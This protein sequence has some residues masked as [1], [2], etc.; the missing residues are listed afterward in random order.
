[1]LNRA[2]FFFRFHGIVHAF[3]HQITFFFAF[4]FT[5]CH[6]NAHSLYLSYDSFC[7]L[8]NKRKAE[9]KLHIYTTVFFQTVNK[10]TKI[11]HWHW[12]VLHLPYYQR[13]WQTKHFYQINFYRVDDKTMRSIN[14]FKSTIKIAAPLYI[15]CAWSCINQKRIESNLTVN[16]KNCHKQT[17]K[18]FGLIII[19][20]CDSACLLRSV[21]KWFVIVEKTTWPI[22][23]C[24]MMSFI[25][26]VIFCHHL[27]LSG[28]VVEMTLNHQKSIQNCLLVARQ[29][30]L[31]YSLHSSIYSLIVLLFDILIAPASLQLYYILSRISFRY[32]S[33]LVQSGKS[34]V[35]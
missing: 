16:N 12:S 14:H 21:V 2:I 35:L 18:R 8:S 24:L 5:M 33:V 10:T 32:F 7:L 27:L 20:K 22:I 4:V 13:W 3:S 23:W 1:M 9:M 25:T 31:C 17:W 6:A 34:I 26:S 15:V 11:L 30:C 19:W 29:S 28:L